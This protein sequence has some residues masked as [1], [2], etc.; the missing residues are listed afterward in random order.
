MELI[1]TTS[2]DNKSSKNTSKPIIKLLKEDHKK[3]K[4]LFTEYEELKEK[5]KNDKKAELVL[6]ICHELTLHA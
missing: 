1:M 5:K 4:E 2:K 3:I 6:K